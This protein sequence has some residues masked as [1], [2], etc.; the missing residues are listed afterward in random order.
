MEENLIKL[1]NLSTKHFFQ[2]E[3]FFTKMFLTKLFFQLKDF[4][5]Q[6]FVITPKVF[7][8][9]IQKR[10]PRPIT[11]DPGLVPIIKLTVERVL[12]IPA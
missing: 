11:F 3:F 10:L 6:N 9:K 5:D 4:L 12:E 1:K 7:K 2:P 8:I